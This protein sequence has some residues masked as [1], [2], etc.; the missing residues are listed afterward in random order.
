MSG[1]GKRQV[2]FNTQERAISPDVNRSQLFNAR[3]D[4]EM[5]RYM[6]DVTGN[7][8][9]DAGA[10]V[11]EPGALESPLRAEIMN[12][13]LVRPQA[14][15][16]NL[17]VDPGVLYALAPDGSADSSNYKYV[18][19]VGVTIA[20]SLVLTVGGAA[21]RIDVI[22]CRI[23]PV[24]DIVADNRDIFNPVTGLFTA[25]S[26]TKERAARLEYRVRAGVDGGGF[27]GTALGW[28]P[29]AVASVPAAAANV[30]AVTFWD[31]RPLI[32]DR[33]YG[34]SALVN[35]R[36]TQRSGTMINAVTLATATGL[37]DAV[38]N[39][40]RVGGRL[41]S[42]SIVADADS[43]SLSAAA[44]Q[45]PGTVFLANVPWYLYLLTPFGLP[46]WARYN[47][48]GTRVPRSPRGIPVVA[49]PTPNT[50]GVPSVPIA[51]PTATGL[52]GS[53]SSGVAVAAGYGDSVAAQRGFF[54]DNSTGFIL[55]SNGSFSGDPMEFSA[56]SAA[57]GNDVFMDYTLIAATHFPA[58]A[59]ALFL[60]LR[61]TIASNDTTIQ[62][63]N[64][65]Q[66]FAPNGGALLTVIPLSPITA[67]TAGAGAFNLV[68]R[69]SIWIPLPTLYPSAAGYTIKIRYTFR[70]I[71]A[72]TGAWVASNQFLRI[73]GW[74]F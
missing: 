36:P 6:F 52:G 51:L 15:S 58:N 39:G 34:L 30:D 41:R 4:A 9:V 32:N 19:D 56:P 25:Q 48:A 3:D 22:E 73:L 29:L 70:N 59:R 71:A 47:A 43:I 38:L 10:V 26:V 7:D 53:T 60:D 46:R 49:I 61:W 28:L 24:D 50:D 55:E 12:G 63:V 68:L 69:D 64:F 65:V 27:P 23:N 2:V 17:L 20:G 40:R 42:G 8:D 31:V 45:A 16:L 67:V 33:A 44:N 57:L 1:P 62:G 74:K 66:I 35:A 54:G 37:I 13:L 11:T 18:R 14:G 5:L 72:T 21:T